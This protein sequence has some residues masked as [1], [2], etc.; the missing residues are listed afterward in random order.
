MEFSESVSINYELGVSVGIAVVE[1]FLLN[2][3][4]LQIAKTIYSMVSVMAQLK[5]ID[6]TKD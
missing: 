1:C 4:F 5:H 3:F 2:D 6:Y